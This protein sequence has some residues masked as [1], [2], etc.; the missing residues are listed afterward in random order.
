MLRHTL[1]SI[2]GAVLLL[3][4]VAGFLIGP[5][6]TVEAL[7]RTFGTPYFYLFVAIAFGLEW[8]IPAERRQRLFSRGMVQDLLWFL[9]YM[10]IGAGAFTLWGTIL[11][12][13][14]QNHLSFL[15]I[16]AMQSWPLAAKVAG[17]VV[18]L[19]LLVWVTHYAHHKIPLLWYFHLVHH[20][21][22]EMSFFNEDRDHVVEKAIN[23]TV[24]FFPLTM[25]GLSYPQ[26]IYVGMLITWY[27]WLYHGNIRTNFGVLKYVLV[28]PQSHRVHHSIELQHWDKNFSA[29]FTLWDR[30]FGTFHPHYDEYPATGIPNTCFPYEQDARRRNPLTTFWAQ[31]VYP[32]R[33][34]LGYQPTKVMPADTVSPT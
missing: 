5:E 10:T 31:L 25:T 6:F 23:F 34:M 24:R 29:Y 30:V 21:Q 26:N 12:R 17:Y 2:L 32:F 18:V 16:D 7:R 8:L 4:M 13:F 28:T 14:Y 19:D 15:T 27:T 11:N 9:M 1:A 20:S 22:K 33:L 3:A